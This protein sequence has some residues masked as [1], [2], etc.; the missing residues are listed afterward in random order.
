MYDAFGRIYA[1]TKK[2]PGYTY[3][4]KN[5]ISKWS[6]LFGQVIGLLICI[7]FGKNIGRMIVNKP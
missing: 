5:C 3:V 1:E 4:F 2:G 7:L 6:P